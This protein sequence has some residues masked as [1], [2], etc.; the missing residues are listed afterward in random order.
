MVNAD[1]MS[2]LIGLKQNLSQ[3]LEAMPADCPAIL[4]RLLYAIR[5]VVTRGAVGVLEFLISNYQAID[6]KHQ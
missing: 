6:T 2:W 3:N 1:F 4:Q 5:A